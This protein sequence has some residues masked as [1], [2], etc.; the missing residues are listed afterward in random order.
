MISTARIFAVALL[1]LVSGRTP[2]Q[3]ELTFASATCQVTFRHP[4]DWVVHPDTSQAG[5]SCAF[6]VQPVTW[7]SLLLEAD[8]VDVYT[9][10][11]RSDPFGFETAVAASAF[12]HRTVDWVLLG[13]QGSESPATGIA[14]RGW[15]GVRGTAT[16]GCYRIEGGYA[17]L[18]DTLAA[19]LG[20]DTRS[21]TLDGGPQSED[22]FDRI[23]ATLELRP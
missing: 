5:E 14:Q 7:D 2:E 15:R 11:L 10:R 21:V 18:C 13:R 1:G 9:V 12:Q 3:A 23:L 4:A 8:G 17:G 20:T 22:V 6:R 16:V 19:V